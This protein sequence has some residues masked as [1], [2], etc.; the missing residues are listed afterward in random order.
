MSKNVIKYRDYAIVR[1]E[2][3]Y[4]IYRNGF[5]ITERETYNECVSFIND[6]T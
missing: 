3:T 6:N 2:G 1:V 5:F 4:C